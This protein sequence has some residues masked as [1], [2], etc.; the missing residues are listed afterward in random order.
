MKRAAFGPRSCGV[1]LLALSIIA[2]LAAPAR[3]EKATPAYQL[4]FDLDVPLLLIGG[5]LASGYLLISEA[6]PPSCAPLCDR[7]K[8]NR[9]D[10]PFAGVYSRNWQA[11]G[12]VATAA[13]LLFAPLSLLV[14]EGARNGIQDVLVVGEAVLMTSGLE[15]M[16]NYAVRRPRPR[17]YGEEAPLNER[18]DGNSGRSFFSGHAGNCLAATVAATITLRRL[19]HYRASWIVFAVGAAGSAFVGVARVGAGSHFPSDSV[20]G[21]AVGAGFGIALPALHAAHVQVSPMADS[22]SQ[23]LAVTGT[24]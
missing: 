17:V 19:G 22:T 18:N 23:G 9:L 3:A 6:A 2:G 1:G 24:F 7:S 20:A 4:S 21:L 12:D 8:V 5:G 11:V 13:T 15:A 14:N 16:V 10:R